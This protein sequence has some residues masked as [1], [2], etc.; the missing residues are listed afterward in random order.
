MW[1]W[2]MVA[3]V[4]SYIAFASFLVFFYVMWLTFRR[5]EQAAANPWGAGATTL[6]WRVPSPP[7]FHTFDELPRIR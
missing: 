3:S 6:E 7:P 5:G 2:N 1:G 4:G